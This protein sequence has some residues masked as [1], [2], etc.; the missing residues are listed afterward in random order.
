MGTRA[1]VADLLRKREKLELVAEQS[2]FGDIVVRQPRIGSLN[3]LKKKDEDLGPHGA[4]DM[5]RT[6]EECGPVLEEVAV[7]QKRNQA[8]P[9]SL[10]VIDEFIERHSLSQF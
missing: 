9:E 3:R 7:L 6:G 4:A 1:I 10:S 8:D 5:V 2:K